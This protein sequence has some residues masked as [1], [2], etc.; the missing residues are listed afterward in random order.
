MNDCL[1]Y[2]WRVLG[3]NVRSGFVT[4]DEE[5]GLSKDSS[6]SGDDTDKTDDGGEGGSSGQGEGTGTVPR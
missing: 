3:I 6:G 5:R 4:R 1:I 2:R